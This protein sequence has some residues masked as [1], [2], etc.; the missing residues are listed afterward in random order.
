MLPPNPS[1][2]VRDPKGGGGVG[3]MGPLTKVPSLRLG[4]HA[5]RYRST[6]RIIKKQNIY[7]PH[8]RRAATPTFASFTS[9]FRHQIATQHD[10]GPPPAARRRAGLRPVGE[11]A[12][13]KQKILVWLLSFKPKNKYLVFCTRWRS[14]LP[15]RIHHSH[16]NC[17]YYS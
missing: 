10:G 15:P 6:R 9:P 16:Y 4:C 11:K 5:L 7:I 17:D 14:L 13:E 2:S 12:M 8:W 3:T 1:G